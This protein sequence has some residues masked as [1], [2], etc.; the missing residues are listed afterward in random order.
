MVIGFDSVKVVSCLVCVIWSLG[1][2]TSRSWR[3]GAKLVNEELK[4]SVTAARRPRD[5]L[6]SSAA[7]IVDDDD[8]DDDDGDD[9]GRE[10]QQPQNQ[11]A[12]DEQLL[13]L[14]T[15]TAGMILSLSQ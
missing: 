15:I 4:V 8:D 9:D 5:L 14:V 13:N 1:L 10:Q 12:S 2:I 11:A 6:Q 7:D 3:V